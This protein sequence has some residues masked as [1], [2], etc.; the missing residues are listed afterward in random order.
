MKRRKQTYAITGYGGMPGTKARTMTH[1]QWLKWSSKRAMKVVMR[2]Q[3]SNRPSRNVEN[4]ALADP[5]LELPGI[6]PD[7]HYPDGDAGSFIPLINK[8]SNAQTRQSVAQNWV[9]AE[10]MLVDSLYNDNR[11]I[12]CS[13]S[14]ARYRKRVR[15]ISLDSYKIDYFE[16]CQCAA[17]C[18]GLI[19]EGFFPSAPCRPGTVFSLRLLRTLHAQGVLGSVSKQAWSAGLHMIFEEDLKTVLP[20]FYHEVCTYRERA[21]FAVVLT[22]VA[23]GCLPSLVGCTVRCCLK[24]QR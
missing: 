12:P 19:A 7:Y 9:D 24:I 16:Y 11:R 23:S 17:A 8:R 21:T 13:C 18:S 3:G 6:P 4:A 10:K 2:P 20:S 22:A 1:A 14:R 5:E 15:F